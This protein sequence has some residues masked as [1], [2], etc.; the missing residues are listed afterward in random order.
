MPLD[1]SRFS[2]RMLVE[3]PF[4]RE[5][6]L[7]HF[8]A[9]PD[10]AEIS[11]E[12]SLSDFLQVHG[13][14]PDA[15]VPELEAAF[16]RMNEI[17]EAEARAFDPDVDLTDDHYLW[18][19]PENKE[20]CVQSIERRY[21]GRTGEI[22]FYGPSNITQWY[23]LEKDMLPW[24]AQNHG[25]GGCIDEDLIHYA[26]RLLYPFYPRAVFFQTGSNDIA[27]GIPQT[28]I[29]ENKKRMYGLFREQMPETHLVVMSGLPLPGRKQFYEA[30]MQ[31]NELLRQMCQA[32]P[33]MHFMDATPVMLSG[34]GE[35]EMQVGEGKYLTPAYFRMDRIHLNVEGH[36]V[37]T[38]LMKQMLEQLGIQP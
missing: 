28:T 15:V 19:S 25:M 3:I 30:T 34:H 8:Q 2:L 18:N 17:A 27:E 22:I 6:L 16:R 20:K 31:T 11:P 1:L 38:V 14:A 23:S 24:K 33:F 21:A 26:P 13:T 5:V 36:N 35:P 32:D 29:L 10:P 37:W 12:T 4:S 9:L 7:R